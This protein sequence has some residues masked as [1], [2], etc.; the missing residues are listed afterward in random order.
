MKFTLHD[1]E[2]PKEDKLFWKD[3]IAASHKVRNVHKYAFSFMMAEF[4]YRITMPLPTS[5][6]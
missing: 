6:C 4:Y 3:I 5:K 2:S 1:N